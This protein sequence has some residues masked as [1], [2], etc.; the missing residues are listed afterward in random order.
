MDK[1]SSNSQP[2]N[3]S[4]EDWSSHLQWNTPVSPTPNPP[5]SR[6]KRTSPDNKVPGA[7]MGPIWGRQDPGGP[8]VG[9][10][11]FA[12]WVNILHVL[13]IYLNLKHTLNAMKNNTTYRDKCLEFDKK[14]TITLP[15][16]GYF[17]LYNEKSHVFFF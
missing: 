10:M 17:I 2:Y 7:N 12:V 6:P 3:N 8:H 9:P 13:Y 5:H 4:V 11:N 14:K 15:Q 1:P 16:K